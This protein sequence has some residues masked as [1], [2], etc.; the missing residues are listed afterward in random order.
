MRAFG[1]VAAAAAIFCA[2]SANATILVDGS[3]TTP[4]VFMTAANVDNGQNFLVNF[5]IDGDVTVTGFNIYS[6]SQYLSLSQA[7]TLKIA[8]SDGNVLPDLT[9][10]TSYGSTLD[11]VTDNGAGVTAHA[12][13]SPIALTAG[14][15]W[16]GLSG[17]LSGIAWTSFLNDPDLARP[18]N[19]VQLG[20]DELGNIR[21]NPLVHSLAFTLEGEGAPGRLAPAVE[22]LAPLPTSPIPEPATWA[23]MIAGF[24]LVGSTLRRRRAITA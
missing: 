13:F 18:T 2:A 24:S 15:W 21:P 1:W 4:T 12:S 5:I 17:H 10:L 9:T 19:Q 22:G 23:M 3:P 6:Q 8:A 16:I 14:S 11:S 20:E 7:V